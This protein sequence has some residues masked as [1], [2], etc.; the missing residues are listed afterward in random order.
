MVSFHEASLRCGNEPQHRPSVHGH[1]W[2]RWGCTCS[3]RSAASTPRSLS[4]AGAR[5]CS[6]QIRK[7]GRAK[8]REFT[9]MTGN[10]ILKLHERDSTM[11][12]ELPKGWSPGGTAFMGMHPVVTNC[13]GQPGTSPAT[14]LLRC[15]ADLM[16]VLMA[17]LTNTSVDKQQQMRLILDEVPEWHCVSLDHG[18]LTF[19]GARRHPP[20]IR[21]H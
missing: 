11:K 10:N 15:S 19:P 12:R 5:P 9:D 1:G 18:C 3:T 7:A 17:Q 4:K 20:A 2:R 21:W 8:P 14:A 6:A 16:P 13:E